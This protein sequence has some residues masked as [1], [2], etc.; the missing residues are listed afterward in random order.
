MLSFMREQ[1]P[2]NASEHPVPQPGSPGGSAADAPWSQEY[3]TVT[4]NRQNLRRSTIVVVV[5]V[6][7]GLGSL[8]LMIRRSQPQAAS[9]SEKAGDQMKIESAISRITGV[10]SEM[11]GR[12]DEIVQKFHDFSDVVQVKVDELVKNPF[13]VEGFAKDLGTGVVLE[14]PAAQAELL[15]RRHLEQQIKTLKLL[16]IMRSSEQG[17]CCMI[18]DQIVRQGDVI[19]GFTIVEIGNNTVTLAWPATATVDAGTPKT[20]EMKTILKLSE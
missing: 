14:D 20:D 10:R 7:V 17:V 12:M 6:A 16:S 8:L 15:R 18:N 4:A 1:E 11:A 9:A 3:L 5:L 19:E 2:K 13:Q